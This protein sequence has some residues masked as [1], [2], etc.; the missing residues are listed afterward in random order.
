MF[1]LFIYLLFIYLFILILI[2]SLGEQR[3]GFD[4]TTFDEIG[5]YA[6]VSTQHRQGHSQVFVFF[7][8]ILTLLFVFVFTFAFVFASVFG[9]AFVKSKKLCA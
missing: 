5:H 6:F 4:H 8:L 9:L 1:Y 3:P 7:S 2:F